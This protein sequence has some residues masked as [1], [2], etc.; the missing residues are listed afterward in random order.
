MSAAH[1]EQPN[2]HDDESLFDIDLMRN[3][4]QIAISGTQLTIEDT[5]EDETRTQA[6]HVLKA[7]QR[8]KR[9]LDAQKKG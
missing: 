6:K 3:Q 7:L 9:H 8:M 4:L 5:N 1:E 2:T